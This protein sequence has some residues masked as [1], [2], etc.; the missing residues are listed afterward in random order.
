MR[1]MSS[2]RWVQFESL[3]RVPLEHDIPLV[4]VIETRGTVRL[5][6]GLPPR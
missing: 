6:N 2:T 3:G 4:S 1:A 5:G